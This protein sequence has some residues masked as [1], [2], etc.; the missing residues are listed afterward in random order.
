[1]NPNAR[2]LQIATNSKVG[3]NLFK[4]AKE[5]DAKLRL[6]KKKSEKRQW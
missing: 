5:F 1:M 4:W 6:R 2:D 3:G